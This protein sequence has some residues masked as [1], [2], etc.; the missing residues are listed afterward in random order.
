MIDDSNGLM[1]VLGGYYCNTSGGERH[2]AEL[3]H[4]LVYDSINM[5]WRRQELIGNVPASR[6]FHSAVTGIVH[7]CSTCIRYRLLILRLLLIVQN[8][9]II[10]CGGKC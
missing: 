5:A 6:I 3:D 9:R 10:I 8:D 7:I 4:A 2:L 1:V